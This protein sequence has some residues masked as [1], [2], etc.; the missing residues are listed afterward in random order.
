MRKLFSTITIAIAFVSVVNAK[1]NFRTPDTDSCY[2]FIYRSG[3]FGGALENFYVWVDNVK[4]CKLSNGR[5]FK[6]GVQPGKH[7][8]SAKLSGV[9]IAKKQTEIPVECEAGKST[10]ISC[11]VKSSALRPRLSLEEV[12]EN[13]GMSQISSMK[14]DDCQGTVEDQ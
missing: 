1:A 3:Q 4:L 5:Y 6:V 8:I 14:V 13:T 2:I 11:T 10:Y 12:V 7:L 9:G